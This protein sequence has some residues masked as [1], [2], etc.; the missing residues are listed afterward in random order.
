MS[1]LA[2]III[3]RVGLVMVMSSEITKMRCLFRQIGCLKNN[4]LL[5]TLQLSSINH[6]IIYN[7]DNTPDF[8]VNLNK[9]SSRRLSL[10]PHING[11]ENAS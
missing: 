1:N 4:R 5:P 9:I 3:G 8:L 10:G 6:V 7:Y 11:F 2:E